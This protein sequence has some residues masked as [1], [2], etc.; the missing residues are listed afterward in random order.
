MVYS[1]NIRKANTIPKIP[2]TKLMA[3]NLVDELRK[4]QAEKVKYGK[5]V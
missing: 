4:V 1:V 5:A 3:M 2:V